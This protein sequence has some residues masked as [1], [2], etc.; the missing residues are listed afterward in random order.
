MSFF[1]HEQFS[2]SLSD[3]ELLHH[4][5]FLLSQINDKDEFKDIDTATEYYYNLYAL[6]EKS[7]NMYTRLT[8]EG[9]EECLK[10]REELCRT[11][12]EMGMKPGQNIEEYYNILKDSIK[13]Q[14]YETTGENLDAEVDL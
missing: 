10:L 5:M 14:I 7:H 9:T 6:I 3:I 1:T 12:R 11:A 13:E 8:L 2:Q 4:C